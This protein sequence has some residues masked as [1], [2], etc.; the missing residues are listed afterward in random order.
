[1]P[2]SPVGI[3]TFI[4]KCFMCSGFQAKTRHYDLS[5][6]THG[7]EKREAPIGRRNRGRAVMKS[8]GGSWGGRGP[9]EREKV[10]LK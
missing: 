6:K 8:Q 3:F 5:R 2:T 1:M 7:R 9:C 4:L 10:E